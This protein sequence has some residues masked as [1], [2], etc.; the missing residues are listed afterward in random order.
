MDSSNRKQ[1]E[2]LYEKV[3]RPALGKIMN[4]IGSQAAAEEILQDIFVDL[5]NEKRKF[6]DIRQAYAWVYR[7]A[8]NKAID[9]L[10]LKKNQ[11]QS[12]DAEGAQEPFI[13]EDTIE[14]L[15]LKNIWQQIHQKWPEKELAVFIYRYFE[16]LSQQEVCEVMGISRRSVNRL[17][18]KVDEKLKKIRREQNG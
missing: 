16:G 3:G 10:R 6:S 1:L 15:E 5:W 8:T 7:C 2:M 14:S 4:L 17:Q 13:N 11:T 9:F 18:E 12:L